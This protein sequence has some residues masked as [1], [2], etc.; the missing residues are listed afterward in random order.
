[1]CHRQYD[2]GQDK[3]ILFHE[4]NTSEIPV[5]ETKTE[6]YNQIH[7]KLIGIIKH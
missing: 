2:W 1:M 5:D 6:K 3:L 7:I 4:M